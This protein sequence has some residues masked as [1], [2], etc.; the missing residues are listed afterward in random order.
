MIFEYVKNFYPG[1]E[2]PALVR[3]A[4]EW[5]R[6]K[7]LKGMRILD[8]APVFRNGV[9][10]YAALIAAGADLTIGISDVMPGDMEIVRR[11]GESGIR[12]VHATRDYDSAAEPYDI[13]LDCAGAFSHWPSKYGVSELTRSG[14]Y[15]YEGSGR[16]VFLADEGRIKR[17]ETCLGTGDGFIRAMEKLGYTE[18]KD[19]R[20]VVFGS[21]K[22]GT[23]II[24]RTVRSGASVDVVTDPE[25]L[26]PFVRGMIQGWADFND[27]E[28]VTR[29]LKGAYAVVTATGHKGVVEKYGVNEELISNGTLLANMGVED[30]YGDS[31]PSEAVLN[32]KRMLNFLLD[33]PT[34]IR[35]I[36]ATMAL[37]NEG[38][39]YLLRHPGG[40][41]TIIPPAEIEEA[42]LET[43][44]RNGV[45]ADEMD[46][47]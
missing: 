43:T 31:F 15:V 22:V 25:T 45:I 1:N 24:Y 16:P 37:H 23:G 34:Q 11:L 28:K 8:G 20:I 6:E 9:T 40:N 7:P 33:E 19:R 2:Y 35:Y 10:K 12:I 3:Q 18:W 30:E 32:G 5:G 41:G 39:L 27:H 13:I 21:G 38:A 36:D 42:I 14:A 46:I 47:I 44:R 4:E 17:I 26:S 29:I